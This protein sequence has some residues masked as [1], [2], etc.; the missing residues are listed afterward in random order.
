MFP[1]PSRLRNR[2]SLRPAALAVSSVYSATGPDMY[3]HF[4]GGGEPF[5]VGVSGNFV[6]QHTPPPA[7]PGHL[8]CPALQEMINPV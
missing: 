4:T 7:L 6:T 3:I 8:C 1:L 2:L 5:N